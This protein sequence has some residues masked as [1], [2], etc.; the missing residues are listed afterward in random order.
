MAIEDRNLSAGTKL[1]AKYKGQVYGAEV[2]QEEGGLRYRLEDGRTIKSPSSAGKA[3]MDGH[4]CNGWTFWSLDRGSPTATPA[5][6]GEKPKRGRK[7]K[8]AAASS[9]AAETAEHGA[10]PESEAELAEATA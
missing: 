3:V 4:A 9:E 1:I 7:S 6:A 5:A 2:V 10:A 8:A